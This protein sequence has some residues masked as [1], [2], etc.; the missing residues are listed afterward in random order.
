[1]LLSKNN[2]TIIITAYCYSIHHNYML[3]TGLSTSWIFIALFVFHP[4]MVSG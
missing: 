1:M 2:M 3:Y 4:E